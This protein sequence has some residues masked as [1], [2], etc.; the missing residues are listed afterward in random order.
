[1]RIVRLSYVILGYR[2]RCIG[3]GMDRGDKVNKADKPM[4]NKDNV[5]KI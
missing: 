3:M 1:M 2:G 5:I 4:E